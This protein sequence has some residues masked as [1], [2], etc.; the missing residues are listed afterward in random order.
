MS[1]EYWLS[2][3]PTASFSKLL[4]YK[5]MDNDIFVALSSAKKYKEVK[6]A[7]KVGGGAVRV[8]KLWEVMLKPEPN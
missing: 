7:I 1:S 2:M 6:Y 8:A 4:E 5:E 3:L